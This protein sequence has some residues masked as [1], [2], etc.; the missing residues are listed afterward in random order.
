MVDKRAARKANEKHFTHAIA[1]YRER[2][3]V[4]EAGGMAH[5]GLKEVGGRVRVFFR[6]RPLFSDEQRTDF[7]VITMDLAASPTGHPC[8]YIHNCAM[9]ADLKRMH[10]KTSK[11]PCSSCF[12]ADA[13][14]E[15]VHQ[16]ASAPLVRLAVA[17]NVAT[18][19]MFGQTGSGK[20]H[21]MDG[22]EELAAVQLFDMI[23][24]QNG[25][26]ADVLAAAPAAGHHATMDEVWEVQPLGSGAGSG[27][28]PASARAGVSEWTEVGDGEGNL[29]YYNQQTGES[30]WEKPP[31]GTSTSTIEP[32]APSASILVSVS[33][34]ELAGKKCLDLLS[35][36]ETLEQI[37]LREDGSG[38]VQMC[39]ARRVPV[40]SA[41]ELL[42]IIHQAKERRSTSATGKNQQSSRSHAVCQIYIEHV[43]HATGS[44]GYGQQETNAASGSK[45]KKGAVKGRRRNKQGLLTLVDC[46]GSERKEDSGEHDVERQRETAE[47][48]SSLHAL[49][50]CVRAIAHNERGKGKELRVPFR[51]SGLQM[52]QV[53]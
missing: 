26:A 41:E 1:E 34:F 51:V 8:A 17:G 49:K 2:R 16:V 48:N 38:K 23:R 53:F 39:G 45:S 9:H 24:E 22:L 6:K 28:A 10:L 35:A 18:L 20:T 30:R 3:G 12:D 33:F 15:Q 14:N 31:N 5:S 27:W 42:D 44:G 52:Y 21:T 11:Y 29:Y 47:I 43:P 4:A 7:D 37:T 40:H 32:T 46:A 25:G 36:G 50:E 13:T 19:F